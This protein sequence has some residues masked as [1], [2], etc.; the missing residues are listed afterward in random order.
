MKKV[1][2]AILALLLLGTAVASVPTNMV[3]A[4]ILPNR[5]AH[6]GEADVNLHY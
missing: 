1:I 4:S 5:F 2:L 6:T 3:Q